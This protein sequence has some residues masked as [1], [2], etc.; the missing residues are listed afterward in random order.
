MWQY[1]LSQATINLG[2][3]KI[4][5]FWILQ[6][7]IGSGLG[8]EDNLAHFLIEN[9]INCCHKKQSM[10]TRINNS[11]AEPEEEQQLKN[12]IV[13]KPDPLVSFGLYIPLK[14]WPHLTKFNYKE[15]PKLLRHLAGEYISSKI[16]IKDDFNMIVLPKCIEWYKQHLLVNKDNDNEP[17]EI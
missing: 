16:E 5:A 17:E 11:E 8:S 2:G 12:F 3:Y 9:K 10:Q 15:L 6:K 7:G 1:F 4:S 14:G 13:R